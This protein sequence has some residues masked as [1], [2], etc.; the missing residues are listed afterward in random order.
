MTFDLAKLRADFEA[1]VARDPIPVPTPPPPAPVPATAAPV[2]AVPPVEGAP[3]PAP[4]PV[5]APPPPPP[6]PPPQVQDID[7]GAKGFHFDARGQP[8]QGVGA[9]QII[10]RHGFAMDCIAGVDWL[11]EQQMEIVY[12]FFH[13]SSSCRAVVRVRVPRTEPALPTICGVF[14]GANWH[15]RETAEFFGIT[16]TGH[17]NLIPLLLP[18]ESTFH[19][20]RK[21]FKGE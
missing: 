2:A 18:E 3:V 21:D 15:E 17:P 10:D 19:P 5:A 20:L 1:L 8:G 6:P 7:F 4:V 13:L 16:F 9:A 12:D 11:A 14:A